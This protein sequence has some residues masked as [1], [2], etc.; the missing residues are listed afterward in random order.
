MV[1]AAPVAPLAPAALIPGTAPPA[2]P[3]FAPRRTT[4]GGDA[5]GGM[6]GSPTAAACRA[7]R[8]RRAGALPCCARPCPTPRA[9][10]RRWGIRMER[11]GGGTNPVQ[12]RLRP[13]TQHGS[14]DMNG[15]DA[16]LSELRAG[17]SCALLLERNGYSL[18]RANSTRRCQS[19]WKRD[20][21]SAS[22]RDPSVL[23]GA[24]T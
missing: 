8:V 6:D 3:P 7:A 2:T 19:A 15:G 1:G 14:T 13:A 24:P 18:D 9:V 10:R 12:F 17:V 20:P 21:G 22:N 5:G 16:E 23:T 4:M 11:G